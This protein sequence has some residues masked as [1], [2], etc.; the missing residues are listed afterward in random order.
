MPF[1][2]WGMCRW[3]LGFSLIVTHRSLIIF[4][5]ISPT[6]GFSMPTNLFLFNLH[7]HIWETFRA[8]FFGVSK[9]SPSLLI[10]F[11]SHFQ[12]QGRFFFCGGYRLDNVL[13]EL[14]FVAPIITSRFL[15]DNCTFLLR[16][17][18]ASNSSP[19]PF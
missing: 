3:H 6:F 10:N 9:G 17:I 14:G 18:K 11:F 15:Q 12:G 8:K 13:K 2:G 7:L 1:I 4:F 5:I 19:L 16:V